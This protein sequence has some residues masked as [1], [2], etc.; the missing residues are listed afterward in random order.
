MR[1]ACLPPFDAIARRW[2]DLAARRQAA[3]IELYASGRWK[4]YYTK[5]TFALRM[6]DVIH[7]TKTWRILAGLDLDPRI[8]RDI[9]A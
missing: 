9:A 5:E 3:Y 7:A 4:R 2:S 1:T 8:E 6:R